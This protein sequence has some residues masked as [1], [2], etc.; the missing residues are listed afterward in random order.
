HSPQ[1]NLTHA[2]EFRLDPK[3]LISGCIVKH[4]VYYAPIQI[5]E[6][7]ST[8]GTKWG[9]KYKRKIPYD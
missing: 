3:R 4:C 8:A 5:V 6:L 1:F 7:L 2:L 9:Q